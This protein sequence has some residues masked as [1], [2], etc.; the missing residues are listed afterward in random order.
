MRG[1]CFSKCR[2][3]PHKLSSASSY[4]QAKHYQIFGKKNRVLNRPCPCHASRGC[5]FPDRAPSYH[6]HTDFIPATLR[7]NCDR[8]SAA[9]RVVRRCRPPRDG[10]SRV[11]SAP[12]FARFKT[13]ALPQSIEHACSCAVA[14]NPCTGCTVALTSVQRGISH[15]ISLGPAQKYPVW[16]HILGGDTL[17]GG[18]L[19]ISGLQE[20]R[21]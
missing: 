8:A 10:S 7:G 11:I 20:S 4:C 1:I 21:P 15:E 13:C 5:T 16:T 12:L 18:A 19:W 6:Q 2:Y 17:G 9:T 14:R 3:V